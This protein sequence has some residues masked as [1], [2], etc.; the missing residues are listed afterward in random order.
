MEIIWFQCNMRRV[1]LCDFVYDDEISDSNLVVD[2]Y[3]G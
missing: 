1:V 3:F 2:K